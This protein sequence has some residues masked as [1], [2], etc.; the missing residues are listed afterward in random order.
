MIYA[1][2]NSKQFLDILTETETKLFFMLASK[3]ALHPILNEFKLHYRK[4]PDAAIAFINPIGRRKNIATIS[5]ASFGMLRLNTYYA[6]NAVY[7]P[8]ETYSKLGTDNISINTNVEL[9]AEILID[10]DTDLNVIINVI[11]DAILEYRFSV[12]EMS[13]CVE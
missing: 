4:K 9:Q 6:E 12:A 7:S 1:S 10:D 8:E 13:R 2:E 3:L 5:K 11:C